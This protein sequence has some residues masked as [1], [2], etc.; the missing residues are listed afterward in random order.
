MRIRLRDAGMRA[1]PAFAVTV[2]SNSLVPVRV[3]R[4]S[5]V[6]MVAG[7]LH[8]LAITPAGVLWAWGGNDYGQLGD[9]TATNALSVERIS[10]A[11]TSAVLTDHYDISGDSPEWTSSSDGGRRRH[12]IGLGGNLDA[13]VIYARSAGAT[14]TV[15][16]L[17]DLHGDVA[18]TANPGGTG[19]SATDT[20]GAF[21]GPTD[22]NT[23]RYGW[24]GGK[25]RATA[26]S[27]YFIH[28]PPRPEGGESDDG[29]RG[30][31][32]ALQTGPAYN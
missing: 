10:L 3:P 28:I 32:R 29:N 16:Q 24:L 21:G 4:L 9:G 22:G 1:T 25:T 23:A 20:Y 26:G 11:G 7:D 17:G 2:R 5:G 14:A 18:A 13:T 12:V 27:W 30:R 8:S 15:L 6:S 19:V 31:P